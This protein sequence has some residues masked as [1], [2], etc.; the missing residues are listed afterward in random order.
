MSEEV[1]LAVV[2]QGGVL[3]HGADRIRQ[4]RHALDALTR[5][6]KFL[7]EMLDEK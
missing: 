6:R 7:E 1:R 2:E 5:V 3:I 4:H